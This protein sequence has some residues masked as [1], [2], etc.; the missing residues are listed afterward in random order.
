MVR[1]NGLNMREGELLR[2]WEL[3]LDEG[4]A[5]LHKNCPSGRLNFRIRHIEEL[6]GDMIWIVLFKRANEEWGPEESLWMLYP[7]STIGIDDG[8]DMAEEM[9]AREC[10]RA[11]ALPKG[12]KPTPRPK[13]MPRSP[14]IPTPAEK[15]KERKTYTESGTGRAYYFADGKKVYVD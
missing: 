3:I 2:G 12:F 7:E 14:P 5:E 4:V 11:P 8:I 1:V 13:P 15:K 10:P 6:F 9:M